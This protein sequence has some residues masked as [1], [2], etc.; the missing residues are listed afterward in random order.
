MSRRVY[1]SS[2]VSLTVLSLILFTAPC[3][4]TP[5]RGVVFGTEIKP[6]DDAT[7]IFR[8]TQDSLIV[9]AGSTYLFTVDTPEDQGLVAT[10]AD[11]PTLLRQI[12]SADGSTQRYTIVSKEGQAR[13][14][15]SR[16]MPS[17]VW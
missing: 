14:Q 16:C 3:F 9:A 4:A 15:S 2:T 10:D 13:G 1:R 17:E 11:V 12:V 6:S 5:P 7:H 8:I